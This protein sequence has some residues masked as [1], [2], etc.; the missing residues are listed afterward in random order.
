MTVAVRWSQPAMGRLII[1]YQLDNGDQ[2]LFTPLDGPLVTADCLL[3]DHRGSHPVLTIDLLHVR[4]LARVLLAATPHL[5][6]A[7][8]TGALVSTTYGGAR[9]DQ[10]ISIPAPA[11]VA[12][13]ATIHNLD[14]ELVLR[15]EWDAVR[16][17]LQDVCQ[18]Y[19]YD[20]VTW[21]DP[22]TPL[23]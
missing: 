4:T 17:S 1:A 2:R 12:V 22:G 21:L 19:G 13:L 9:I 6:A 18:A 15:A 3:L 14:G 10:P 20:R 11:G 5:A 23:R 8:L 16:G 7:P